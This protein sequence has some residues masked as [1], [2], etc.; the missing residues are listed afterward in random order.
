[1]G[2]AGQESDQNLPP[3]YNPYLIEIGLPMNIR[4]AKVDELV[5][6]LARLTGEDVETALERA[7]EERLSRVAPPIPPNRRAAM[8]SFFEKASRL[9]V[10]DSRPADEIMGYDRFGLPS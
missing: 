6:R 3:W 9:P 10:L 4:S 1:M 5:Q 7:I 8:D 2:I